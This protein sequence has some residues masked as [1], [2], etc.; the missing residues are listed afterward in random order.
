M[1][2]SS[3]PV[4]ETRALTKAYGGFTAVGPVDLRI[5]EGTVHA[6]VGPNGAG[7]TTLFHLLT[8]HVPAGTGRIVLDGRDI[9]G[10]SPERI[11]RLGVAR[12]FQVTSL[13]EHATAAEHLE[14]AL[15]AGSPLGRAFWR[16]DRALARHRER[17]LE[18][19]DQVGLARW[20][21]EPAGR[22]PYGRGR[23][24]ELALAIALDPKLLLLDEPTA[25]M[26]TEDIERTVELIGRVR[27][28]RTVVLVE[29][30]MQVVAS[31]AERVTVLQRGRILAEGSYDDVRSDERVV[32]AYLGAGHE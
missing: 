23:A 2:L 32:E 14:L 18:L 24:L 5:S 20:A 27:Q 10:H 15:M 9:T 25:G 4:L 8:G 19:L 31:L 6:L 3:R 29:H 17:A 21:D 30:N 13:F 26:G 1:T 11:A 12:S 22:L 16:S 28:G 7:K